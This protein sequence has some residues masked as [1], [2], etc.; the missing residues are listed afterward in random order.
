MELLNKPSDVAAPKQKTSS[1][2]KFWSDG[3][4]SW[5]ASKID[6]ASLTDK[7]KVTQL[8]TY[9]KEQLISM[10]DVSFFSRIISVCF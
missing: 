4:H 8:L 3:D 7:T 6:Q 2:L 5:S 1:F 10:F 9:S